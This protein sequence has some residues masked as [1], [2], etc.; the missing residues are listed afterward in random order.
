MLK[1]ARKKLGL[2]QTEAAKL[3]G[4]SLVTWQNWER[5]VTTPA[6]ENMAKIYKEFKIKLR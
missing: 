1:N 2:S 6:P 5:G 3:I 4:V